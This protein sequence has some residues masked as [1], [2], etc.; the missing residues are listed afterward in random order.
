[1]DR[2]E[3]IGLAST[4][5]GHG[6]LLAVIALG[7]FGM[8]ET[9]KKPGVLD[10]TLSGTGS[11]LPVT[12][13]TGDAM[14]APELVEEAELE[15]E[16]AAEDASEASD[17]A[18][19]AEAEAR[20]AAAAAQR[21]DA[22]AAEKRAAREAAQRAAAKRREAAAKARRE[23]AAREKAAREKAAREKAAREKA[24]RDFEQVGKGLGG[25]A[26]ATPGQARRAASI[27]IGSKV[28]PLVRS[29]APRTGDNSMLTVSVTLT[30]SRDSR[31]RSST[32]TGV[33]GITSTN[34]P[35]VEPMK[36]CVQQALKRASP[37]NLNPADFNIWKRHR[38]AIEA[39]FK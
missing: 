21:A 3:A 7:I 30:F 15:S 1:M 37:Y 11:P 27:S 38:V 17:A 34:R 2:A 13:E 9:I 26:S 18:A 8:D 19:K 28:A 5:G 39:N 24:Q 20:R 35:Q 10:V 32:I 25:N 31:L 12:G 14:A 23:K 6:L 22:T 29:C 33:K 16:A 36:R 4:V